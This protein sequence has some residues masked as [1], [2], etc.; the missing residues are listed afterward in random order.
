MS[1]RAILLSMYTQ[2]EIHHSFLSCSSPQKAIY[3]P[4]RCL[5]LGIHVVQLDDLTVL[6]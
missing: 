5:A 1:L 3:T 6:L 4:R 2:N